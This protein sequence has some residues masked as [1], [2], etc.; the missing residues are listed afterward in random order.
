LTTVKKVSQRGLVAAA[1]M[2][3]LILLFYS[4]ADAQARIVSIPCGQDI[5][6]TINSDSQTRSTRFVLGADC[7]FSASATVKPGHLDEVVC[8]IPP[9]FIQRG[10]AF[11]P[12]TRCTVAGPSLSQVFK[13]AGAGG[14]LA[15]V[16]FEGIKITGGN[17]N[18][19][20]GSGAAIAGGTT[21]DSSRFYGVEI[22]DNDAA[23]VQSGRGTFQRIE[24]TNNSMDPGSIGFNAA[25]IKAR[26]EAVILESYVHNTQGNGIW[27][28]NSCL[29]TDL[30]TFW[31]H[32]NLVVGS[33][34]SGIRWEEVPSTGGEALIEGNEVHGK[35][36]GKPGISAHD[37]KDAVIRNNVFGAATIAYASYPK[38]YDEGIQASDSGRSD[39]PDLLNIDILNNTLNGE[40]IKGC[41]LPNTVVA[42]AG[43]TPWWREHCRYLDASI[44]ILREL[45]LSVW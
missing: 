8:A 33:G 17:F 11:D 35:T 44:R 30:G 7:V 19:T 42:C 28:D 15:Q 18:G 34:R 37:A 39:R 23:G 4:V 27:C 21:S 16:Y 2:L 14:G 43:D 22:R 13:P 5:D 26:H 45:I 1:I 31:V 32:H 38:N 40:V 29:D 3:P 9:T 20:S 36:D 24:L 10:P 41:E 25:G 6:A 12:T